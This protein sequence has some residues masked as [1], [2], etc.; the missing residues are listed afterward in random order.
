[1]DKSYGPVHAVKDLHLEIKKGQV[2]GILGPN[3]SGK[4]TTLAMILGVVSMDKGS[5][6]WFGQSPN[7]VNQQKIG[8][9]LES[10]NFYPY[11]N[12]IENLKII[13]HIKRI[14][15]AEVFRVL[16]VVGLLE[17]QRSKFQTL[18]LGMKQRLALASVLLGD[19]EV[20]V[21][22]EPA[23]GLDPEGI[24]EVREIIRQE[25]EKG[26]TIIM[27]SHILVEV[28]KVCSHVA[29][30]R[31]GGLIT[32]S[33]VGSLLKTDVMMILSSDST[34][35]L[36]Q[37][38]KT[39]EGITSMEKEG[40]RFKVV[41]KEN[42]SPGDLNKILVEKGIALNQMEIHKQ[43]LEEQFLELVK[44]DDMEGGQR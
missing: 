21:L 27:A 30:L 15:E 38:L 16:K 44:Q 34:N 20:L 12:L 41:L 22:D 35:E 4:T 14:P 17:R 28:E 43:S 9:M 31:K 13:S 32:T 23:N 29:I 19:P 11:L 37:F 8:S 6:S 3:G 24:A 26:K 18:S 7:P 36:H 2:F 1:M 40:V 42:V 5:Y 10:P 33:E 25:A 39:Y